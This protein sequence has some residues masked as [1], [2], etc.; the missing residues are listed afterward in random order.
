MSDPYDHTT[1]LEPQDWSFPVPIAY[2][3]GLLAELGVP[4]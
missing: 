3:P 1:M 4:S 2:G